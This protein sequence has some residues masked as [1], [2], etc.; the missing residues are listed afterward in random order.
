M[1]GGIDC[2]PARK[3]IVIKGIEDQTSTNITAPKASVGLFSQRMFTSVM[4]N[5]CNK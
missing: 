3:V 4:L 1:W 2:N 5:R